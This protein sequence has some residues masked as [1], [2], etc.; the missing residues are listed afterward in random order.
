MKIHFSK[1]EYRLLLDMI[2]IAGWVLNAYSVEEEEFTATEHYQ[3]LSQRIMSFAKEAGSD[4]RVTFD[5]TLEQ[6]FGTYEYEMEGEYMEFVKA[7][8][9]ESFWEHLIQKLAERDFLDQTPESVGEKMSNEDVLARIDD[10]KTPY[11]E[12]FSEYGID[13]LKIVKT[14]EKIIH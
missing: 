14:S 13:N 2:Q 4:D 12:E 3:A 8:E 1:K 7:F 6:Y 10:L 5:K 11:G 9:D